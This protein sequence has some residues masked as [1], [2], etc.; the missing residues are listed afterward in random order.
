ML[1]E[2]EN[3]RN[4]KDEVNAWER[5][6]VSRSSERFKAINIIEQVFDSFVELHGDRY[7]GDDNSMVCGIA[8]FGNIPVTVIGQ[9]KG[10]GIENMKYRQYGMN[11]PEGYRKSVRLMKQAEKFN[12]PVICII[13]TPGAY[14]GISAEEHGQAEAIARN[15][16]VMMNLRVPILS[17]FI[18]EGGSGGALALGVANKM[19]ILENACFSVVSPEGCSSILWKDEKKAA[20]A[21]EL[22]RMTS[23]DLMKVGIIDEIISEEGT[24]LDICKEISLCISNI[25]TEFSALTEEEIVEQRKLKFRSFDKK[26]MDIVEEQIENLCEEA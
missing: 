13:D 23:T 8:L 24:F 16:Q 4:N 12:R 7:T 18:G 1:I 26:F 17:F 6:K 3:K 19:I 25:L 15:L 21:A 20:V 11:N 14:P 2:L 9:E 22:L 10:N 5:V